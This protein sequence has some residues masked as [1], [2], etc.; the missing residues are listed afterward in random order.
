MSKPHTKRIGQEKA[1]YSYR[2]ELALTIQLPSTTVPPQPKLE[3]S[4][5][6]ASE[7]FAHN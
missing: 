6:V 3:Y 5:F 7:A 2:A 1:E 4:Y